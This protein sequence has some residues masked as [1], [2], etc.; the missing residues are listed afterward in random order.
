MHLARDLVTLNPRI[1]HFNG[2]A[3]QVVLHGLEHLQRGAL[4]HVVH[5]LLVG[6]AVD[7]HLGGI[8]DPTLSHNLASAMQHILRHACVSLKRQTDEVRCFGVVAHEEPRIHGNTVAAHAGTRLQDVHARMFVRDADNLRHIHAANAT[9]L[10][11]LVGERDVNRTESVLDDLGHL[12]GTD[13]GHTDFALTEGCVNPS[14]FLAHLGVVRANCTVV[15]KQL[16]NHVSG[17]D[18][19]R[20]VHE[21]NILALSLNEQRAHEAIHRVGRNSRL[22]HEHGTLRGDLKHRLAG[23]NHITGVNLL[24]QL[25]IGRRHAHDVGIARLILSREFNARFQRVGEQLVKPLLL[26]GGVPGIQSC[27][28]FLIVV[29]SHNLHAM[30]GHHKRGGQPDI[31]ETDYV[32]HCIKLLILGFDLTAYC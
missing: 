32:N 4:A 21:P 22:N 18:A 11:E 10:S 17:D 9:D 16:V 19:L 1:V 26:E 5:V 24:V 3:A 13:V 31:A 27:H 14:N 25:V 23:G 12:G 30:R 7:T 6:Q 29:G 2:T 20:G 15:V 8:L 28:E